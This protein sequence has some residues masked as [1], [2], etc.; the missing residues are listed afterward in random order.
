[1]VSVLQNQPDGDWPRWDFVE[2]LLTGQAFGTQIINHNGMQNEFCLL[3]EARDEFFII[4]LHG[5]NGEPP[6]PLV[7]NLYNLYPSLAFSIK[8]DGTYSMMLI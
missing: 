5:P 4:N 7:F 2:G 1:M 3:P 8:T 6:L